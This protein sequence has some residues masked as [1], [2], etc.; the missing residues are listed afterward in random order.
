MFAELHV[1]SLSPTSRKRAVSETVTKG[2]RGI[3]LG[4][5][6][7]GGGVGGRGLL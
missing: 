5:G 4:L 2:T 1:C 7:A 6:V 3:I